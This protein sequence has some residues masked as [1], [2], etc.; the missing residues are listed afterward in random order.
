MIT[1][2]SVGDINKDK[3]QRYFRGIEN[4]EREIKNGENLFELA[5]TTGNTI[6][7]NKEAV[8]MAERERIEA[9]IHAYMQKEQEKLNK[10]TEAVRNK[11]RSEY[12]KEEH[13]DDIEAYISQEVAK[14]P[15]LNRTVTVPPNLQAQLS[16]INQ[17]IEVLGQKSKEQANLED[18]KNTMIA[19]CIEENP[20]ITSL[21]VVA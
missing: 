17:Q 11:A 2:N 19:N 15:N 9:E 6:A 16:S 1:F 4:I 3:V 5:D 13:G 21:D 14:N 18:T 12:N 20:N 7:D 10:E 8:L